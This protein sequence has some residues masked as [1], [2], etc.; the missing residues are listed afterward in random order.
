VFANHLSEA[1]AGASLAG[2]DHLARDLWRA[3]A[4]GVTDDTD[5][6]ALSAAIEDRRRALRGGGASIAGKPQKPLAS[7]PTR[8]PPRRVQVSPNRR[9]SIERR[10]RLAASGPMPP[11]L[12]SKFTQ[13]ELAVLRIVADEVRDHGACDRSY[14][15]LAARAGCCRS[16]AR[17]AIRLA[18]RMGLLSIE[19]RPRPGRKHLT[20]LVRVRSME[21]R[22][23]LRLD[24][25]HGKVPHGHQDIKSFGMKRAGGGERATWRSGERSGERGEKRFRQPRGESG[26]HWGGAR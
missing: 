4:A 11:T 21:W 9:R 7:R 24:R 18:A 16:L 26:E 1:V 23:W 2:C 12:A 15:E 14:D 22:V 13:G 6:E 17:R 19:E 8:F 5:A 20:N 25:G 10:R 3:Y